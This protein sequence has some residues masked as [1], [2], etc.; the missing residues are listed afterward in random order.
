MSPPP[1]ILINATSSDPNCDGLQ[2]GVLTFENT[3]GGSG[4]FSYK[5][6]EIPFSP[7][8]QFTG[9]SPGVYQIEVMDQNG[10]LADT[11]IT[12]EAPDIPIISLPENFELTLGDSIRLRVQRNMSD[13]QMIDWQST[14]TLNLVD[15]LAPFVRPFDNTTYQL[16]VT[17]V[18]G[19]TASDSVSIVVNKFRNVFLP[20]AFSPNQDGINDYFNLLGGPE[21]KNI[22]LLQ[23]YNRWGALVYEG[24]ELP[25]A[26]PTSGWN[27]TFKNEPVQRGIYLWVAKVEFIDEVVLSLIHI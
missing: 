22:Q 9:L 25:A 5:Y 6:N 16:M 20:N 2:T 7:N 26:N 17:S 14:G 4:G 12:L 19:C 11:T 8:N 13:I 10:C 18:D 15:S 24:T 27:G 23:V 3:T 21:V 1:A